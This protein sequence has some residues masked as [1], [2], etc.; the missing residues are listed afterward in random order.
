MKVT[1]IY[2]KKLFNLGNYQNVEI[3]INVAIND[4]ENPNDALLFAETF[5]EDNN[6]LREDKIKSKEIREAQYILCHPDTFSHK[7]YEKAQNLL[8]SYN[9][10]YN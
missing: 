9:I 10:E 5:I 2:Y 4:E 6:P 1:E 3:G 8:D 7:E